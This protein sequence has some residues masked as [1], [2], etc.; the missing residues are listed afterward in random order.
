MR[1]FIGILILSLFV[2][3]CL[4]LK[5]EKAKEKR[6]LKG[7]ETNAN[8]NWSWLFSVKKWYFPLWSKLELY[9][10]ASDLL[11][12]PVD[13]ISEK[14][15]DNP[16]IV[17]D[18]ANFKMEGFDGKEIEFEANVESDQTMN[19]IA[20]SKHAK[21]GRHTLVDSDNKSWVLGLTCWEDDEASW[22]VWSTLPK[23]SSSAKEAIVKQ[24]KAHGFSEENFVAMSYNNCA[25]SK[26]EL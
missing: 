3:Q 21:R 16:C 25:N 8:Q 17:G 12:K 23:L 15:L 24:I 22:G 11:Q 26:K 14:A 1:S 6:C 2:L 5:E 20:K 13:S 7:I 18:L 19:F 9:R 4:C 10:T